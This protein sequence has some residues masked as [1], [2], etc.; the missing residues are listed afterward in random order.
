MRLPQE[1]A[2][3]TWI[4]RLH[5]LLLLLLL[6]TPSASSD[7][8]SSVIAPLASQ[9]L[10]L[11]GTMAGDAI[12]VVGER[13]HILKSVDQG[14]SWQQVIVPTRATLT[15]VTFIDAKNGFAVGH[16]ALILRSQNG[17]QSWQRMYYAPEEERPLL[18]VYMHSQNQITAIGAYGLYLHS[19]DGGTTWDSRVFQPLDLGGLPLQTEN[20]E[21]F[22][23]DL[24]LN[25]MA[26]SD[27]GRLYI[28]A[29]A[30]AIYRSDDQGLQWRQ[31]PSPYEGSFFGTLPVTADEVLA[32]GLQGRLF[33]SKD[34]GETWQRVQT[35]TQATL[36]NALRLRQGGI[37]V[38]GYSGSLLFAEHGRSEFKL[39]QLEQ[40]MG[41][42]SSIQLKNGDLLL[43][44]A[45]GMMHLPLTLLTH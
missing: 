13:G 28:A 33:Y 21:V 37:V 25:H 41:I 6:L 29:E 2:T 15:A 4:G 39:T 40:R 36:T 32:F 14:R 22:L 3:L 23:G 35:G 44:G 7:D 19:K 11:D 20:K 42:S 9:S 8:E 18:D 45:G 5:A 1:G 31:L 16:D 43:L 34:A 24:H 38:S 10:I 17:G 26:V 27:T 30:G 12:V